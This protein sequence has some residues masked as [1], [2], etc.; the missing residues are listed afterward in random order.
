[1][2]T[3]VDVFEATSFKRVDNGFVFR[4]P[5]PWMFG[6]ARNY[7]VNE[8]Q[9]NEIVARV[10]RSRRRSLL[11]ALLLWVGFF[12]AFVF[13]EAFTTGHEDPTIV[14]AVVLILAAI[15][16]LIVCFHVW[17][18]LLLRPSI[19]GLP[20]SDERTTFSERREA[21]RQAMQTT[22]AGSFLLPGFL[23][24][25]SCIFS[26]YSFLLRSHG[27]HLAV[28]DG[29]AFASLF[30]T[31]ACGIGAAI[32]FYREIKASNS[33]AGGTDPSLQSDA[34]QMASRVARIE[35]ENCRLRRTLAGIV[36]ISAATIVGAMVLSGFNRSVDTDR[37][38]VR[39]AKGEVAAILAA[40]SNN[41]PTLGLY[42]AEHKLGLLLGLSDTGSPSIGIYGPDHKLRTLFGL[43]NTGAPTLR[44]YDFKDDSRFSASLANDGSPNLQL[45][46]ADGKSRLVFTVSPDIPGIVFSDSLGAVR[47]RLAVDA[48]GVPIRIFDAASSPIKIFDAAGKEVI[49]PK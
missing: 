42:G 9:K 44:F 48:T 34:D 19:R 2:T 20:L 11:I 38:I 24:S 10:K 41:S 23:F 33:G 15:I 27:G 43:T 5:N 40:G 6:R 32:F 46:G 36:A 14:D 13:A 7:L 31:I 49:A 17:Y 30:A 45:N 47:M 16:S 39:N 35:D 22:A 4:A 3:Q 29:T 1:M 25:I 8:T 37:L 18:I 21:A 28:G 26:A 12:A